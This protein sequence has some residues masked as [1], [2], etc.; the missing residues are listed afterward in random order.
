MVK[1]VKELGGDRCSWCNRP[2]TDNRSIIAGMGKDC[3]GK[4][5]TSLFGAN[6]AELS[7]E[8][9]NGMAK[10]ITSNDIKEI[11][12]LYSESG[13]ENPEEF[14]TKVSMFRIQVDENLDI[15]EFDESKLIDIEIDRIKKESSKY[16]KD[17]LFFD[18]LKMDKKALRNSTNFEDYI[19]GEL[20]KNPQLVVNNFTK[21]ELLEKYHGALD[22][23]ERHERI[24]LLNLSKKEPE[25][26]EKLAKKREKDYQALYKAGFTDD[27]I[28]SLKESL[29]KIENSITMSLK[30]E[31]LCEEIDKLE[32]MEAERR[33]F[34]D[35]KIKE[36]R[37]EERRNQLE[38]KAQAKDEKERQR[39][40]A[41]RRKQEE[42]EL[43]KE[44][45]VYWK[46]R[47]EERKANSW[48]GKQKQ[49]Q[50]TEIER[51][52]KI[53]ANKQKI[54]GTFRKARY[55]LAC[56][57]QPLAIV[58]HEIVFALAKDSDRKRS[59]R[60]LKA[61]FKPVMKKPP[62]V[63]RKEY[64][65]EMKKFKNEENARLK[66]QARNRMLMLESNP[67]LYSSMK[68][69]KDYDIN[70]KKAWMEARKAG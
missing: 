68:V 13:I 57:A 55:F 58:G 52:A 34:I 56:I 66:A 33:A 1:K 23:M 47:E 28:L 10:T 5:M 8:Q 60:K 44:W 43:E 67:E 64:E 16:K 12:K 63:I 29:G 65:R 61:S 6:F 46:K 31:K 49:K 50:L 36:K 18:S 62:H 11:H 4:S 32:E 9:Y 22:Y 41:Q 30:A 69:P 51:K 27:E 19:N 53:L 21:E 42:K 20:A 59:L 26:L 17:V 39:E 14:F 24:A 7:S 15:V 3:L 70:V 54:E 38:A 40:E 25:Q 45:Q 37:E 2:L 48:F 35:Q